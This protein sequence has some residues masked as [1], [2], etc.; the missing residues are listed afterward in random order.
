MFHRVGRTR[1]RCS[2]LRP[3]KLG[4]GLRLQLQ[5]FD[6][7]LWEEDELPTR[8]NGVSAVSRYLQEMD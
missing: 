7:D 5:F 8:L 3:R 2:F 6:G 4:T 1:W